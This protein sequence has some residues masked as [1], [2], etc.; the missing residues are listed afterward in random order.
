MPE[1]AGAAVFAGGTAVTP[2]EAPENARLQLE[3]RLAAP[4]TTRS[5]RPMSAGTT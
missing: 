4:T 5:E 3:I 1:I 2:V